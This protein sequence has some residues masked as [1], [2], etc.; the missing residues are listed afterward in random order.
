MTIVPT[1]ASQVRQA[2]LAALQ[3]AGHDVSRLQ[4]DVTRVTGLEKARITHVEW[5]GDLPRARNQVRI[6]GVTG[7]GAETSGWALIN[8]VH[9]DSVAVAAANVQSGDEFDPTSIDFE[10]MDVTSFRGQPLRPADVATLPDGAVWSR[11]VREGREVRVDDVRAPFAAEVGD[12]ILMDYAR[13]ALRLRISGRA[14]EGG[15]VGDV[16]RIYSPETRATYRAR[17][18]GQGTAIWIETRS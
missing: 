15:A 2:F 12:T 7:D 1:D 14:R 13:G 3:E 4:V 10:W 16:I 8:V 11:N 17:L 5:S 18:T 9:F 6:H